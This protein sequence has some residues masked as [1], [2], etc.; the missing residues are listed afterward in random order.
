VKV[1]SRGANLGKLTSN[2]PLLAI[3][4]DYFKSILS[5]GFYFTVKQIACDCSAV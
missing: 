4:W 1:F 2:L 5:N 3:V